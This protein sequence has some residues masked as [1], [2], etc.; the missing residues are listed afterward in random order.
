M[1]QAKLHVELL[2][3]TPRPEEVVAMGA[4]LC[5]SPANIDDLKAGIE[6]KDQSAFVDKLVS[7]GHMS[8][9]E[10]VTFTFGVEGISRA[11]SHQIVR[12]RV[13]SYCLS[14]D[15]VIKGARQKSRGYKRF[16]VKSLFD[17]T[18]SPHGRSR[19]KLI[20]LNSLDEE[21]QVFS[22]GKIKDIFYTGKNEV[23]EVKLNNG[24][25][26]KA[27][28]NH[29]FLTKEGWLPLKD[30]A[31]LR[32]KLAVNGVTCK[33]PEFALLRDKIW[34]YERYNSENLTQEEIGE[35]LGCSKHTVRSWIRRHGLQKETG[36]L[37]GHRPR[38]G[39]HWTLNR[40]RTPEERR[41]LSEQMKGLGNPQWK[42][43]I[44]REAVRLRKEI[45]PE[46]RRSIY[47]RDGFKCKLCQKTGGQLTLHHKIP[48]YADKTKNTAPE[49]LV[50]LC[51]ECHRKVNNNENEYAGLFD[52]APVPY[53]SRSNGCYR[54]VKWE[55]IESI[56]PKGIEETY[57]IAMDGPHHNFVANGFVVHNSQQSQRYVGEQTAKHEGATFEYVIPPSVVDAGQAEW[58]EE[59]MQTIQGWYDELNAALGE[60]GEKSQEDARFL[61]PN[62]AET[63]IVITMNARELLHFFRVRCCNR[64]QWEIRA[65]A[66]QMLVKLKEAAPKLFVNAGPGCVTGKCPEGKMTCGKSEEM[67]EKFL[68]M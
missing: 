5:Y 8:P 31:R 9:V 48:L 54:T 55:E 18:L 39:Y 33:A 19:L 34:L 4:K 35:L 51:R 29:R 62:A 64:A 21:K 40:K 49:N 27:T 1:G 36:G 43:G 41:R 11:C 20:R 52:T 66:E 45:S 13:A 63:K 28:P 17:R 61:L 23:W 10:H 47:E 42:G 7:M 32:P 24:R 44:T 57:D 58:F 53:H 38:T 65:M 12:H 46:L 2:R 67:R 25:T 37:H 22:R 56:T 16:T 15:T 50:T 60:A 6:S 14:G 30:I 3:H 68:N 26:I 59:K